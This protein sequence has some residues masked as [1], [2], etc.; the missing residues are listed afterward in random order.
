MVLALAIGANVAI[1]GFIDAALLRPLPYRHPDQLVKIWDARQSQI[2]SRFEAS[3]PDYLDWKQQSPAFSSLA[4]Y[5]TGGNRILAGPNGP[6]MIEVGPVS[7]NFFQTL[8]VSPI[9][10]RVF[11][12]GENLASSPQYAVLTYGSWQRRFSGRPDIVGQTLTLSGEPTTIIGVLPKDFQFAPRGDVELYLAMR[13]KGGMLSR[14]NLHWIHPF[15]RLK[16]GVSLQQAQSMMNALAANLEKQYPDSNKEL[17]TVVIPLTELI[18]G[19]IKPILMVLMGAVGMLLLIACANIANLL[20][21]RSATR[22]REIALRSALGAGRWRVVRQL[23]TEGVVLAAAGT[24]A[25]VVVAILAMRWMVD[26]VPQ[27]M[28]QSMPYLKQAGVEPRILVFAAGLALLTALL[29]SLPPALRLSIPMLN[30]ALKEGGQLSGASSWKRVGSFLVVA[31]LAIS[32]VL[33]VGSALLLKSLF[34]LLNVDAGFNVSQLTTFYVFPDSHRYDQEREALVME[35]NLI[36]AL[37]AVPGVSAAG[38]TSTPPIVGGNTSLFRVVG[39]PMTTRPYEANSRDVDAGYFST[40][41]ATLRSGRYFDERDS[42]TAPQTVII[43]ETLAKMAFGTED[44]VGKEIVFTYNAQQKPRQIVGVLQ[45][46][47]EGALDV[48]DK[49][50]IYTPFAQGPDN[51]FAVVVRSTVDPGSLRPALEKAVHDIDPGIVL[52]QMQTM[53]DLIAQSPAAALHRYPAWLV[54]VF[55]FTALLLAVVGLYGIMS[56]SVSQRTREIGIRMA[57]GAPRANVLKLILGDGA[58]LAAIGIVA[59]V[60]GAVL[61]GYVLRSLLFGVAPWDPATLLVVTTILCGVGLFASYIPAR[62][63]AR[64]DPMQALRYE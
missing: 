30:E 2:D 62:R 55:A 14:R 41:Q 64:V 61:A 25:G 44:P 6:E 7:D 16:P 32:A 9:L 37:A 51:I 59:G 22:A 4:A 12:N 10:G 27:S 26:A 48:E 5:S 49:P 53:Q 47:H 28:L 58:R 21:A 57:L 3:Y 15:G 1:F 52:Y 11:L 60:I 36:D 50:A 45:D 46:V 29:F 38:A 42:A 23:I 24:A 19:P 40:L 18:T 34:R 17:R 31:E 20:L 39:A 33:L 8:G 35:R 56:Y 13:P 54:S 43:N 63:A